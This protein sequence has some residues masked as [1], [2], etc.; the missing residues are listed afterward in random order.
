MIGYREPKMSKGQVERLARLYHRKMIKTVGAS[1]TVEDLT[2]EFWMVWQVVVERFDPTRGFEFTAFLGVSIRNKAMELS[3]Y[4]GRRQGLQ[5]ESLDRPVS[6]EF[7]SSMIDLVADEGESVETRIIKSQERERI[8]SSIDPRLRK[9]VSLLE[10]PPPELEQQV[11]ALK[12]KAA[13]ARSRGLTAR[14]PKDLTLGLISDLVGVSRCVR[15]KL[16][17]Q[18]QEVIG[19][20]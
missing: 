20:D 18:M 9:I 2:Q 11:E 5:A 19:R 16:L 12:A 3:R 6:D 1:L 15:Y 7:Q 8:M 13:F 17:E 4:Y 14:E 10:N